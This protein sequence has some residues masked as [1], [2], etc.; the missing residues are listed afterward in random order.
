M[1]DMHDYVPEAV[2]TSFMWKWTPIFN[3]IITEVAMGEF[4]SDLKYKGMAEGA[5]SIAPWN[6]DIIPQEVINQCDA[7]YG[8]IVSSQLRCDER[9]PL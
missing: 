9:P 2:L 7:M 3:E 6:A 5:A 4:N 1:I 8:A